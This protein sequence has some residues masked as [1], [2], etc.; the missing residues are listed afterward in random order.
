[1]LFRSGNGP[2]GDGPGVGSGPVDE[3]GR[4]G[5]PTRHGRPVRVG[6]IWDLTSMVGLA[7]HCGELLDSGATVPPGA[8]ADLLARGVRL[9]RM[10]I[11][12]DT[13]ELVDLTPRTWHLPA[14]APPSGRGRTHGPPVQL[15]VILDTRLHTAL[16][17][18]DLT[19]LDEATVQLVQDL[20]AA[21]DAAHPPVRD[22]VHAL[23]AFLV[24]AESLDDQ[25]HAEIP[26]PALAEFVALRD[27]HPTHPTAGPSSAAA[28]DL[29]H[30]ISRATGGL[31]VRDNL[32]ALGRRWHILRTHGRWTYQRLGRGWQWTSP[33]GRTYLTQPYD[34]RL[35]A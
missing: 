28:A 35:C 23:V 30:T 18:G 10:L 3:A 31:T 5:A 7:K 25:P 4:T 32:T 33:T 11:D 1:M 17:T 2:G 15:G 20:G 21:L 24:T 16:S 8:M 12:P 14:A 6:V 27:R 26:K 13:G 29:D 19:D 22:V 9:R 34:Y